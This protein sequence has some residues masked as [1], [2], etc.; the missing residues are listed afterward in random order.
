VKEQLV[1]SF[2]S[3]SAFRVVGTGSTADDPY[4][5]RAAMEE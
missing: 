4:P 3:F 5:H 2:D 1:F